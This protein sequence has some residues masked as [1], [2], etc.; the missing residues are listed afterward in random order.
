M[1]IIM[2]PPPLPLP[3]LQVFPPHVHIQ[4][5]LQSTTVHSLLLLYFTPHTHSLP[6]TYSSLILTL[7]RYYI[8]VLLLLL[9]VSPSPSPTKPPPPPPPHPPPPPRLKW[10]N[11]QILTLYTLFLFPFL[12]FFLSCSRAQVHLPTF[13]SLRC[14]ATKKKPAHVLIDIASIHSYIH[15]YFTPL[16]T[17][18]D[19]HVHTLSQLL[20]T[21]LLDHFQRSESGVLSV[22]LLSQKWSRTR[23]H[24]TALHCTAGYYSETIPLLGPFSP[25]LAVLELEDFS[26]PGY[27]KNQ[28]PSQL[29]SKAKLNRFSHS[30]FPNPKSQEESKPYQSKHPAHQP[31]PPNILSG[32][33]ATGIPLVLSLLRPPAYYQSQQRKKLPPILELPSLRMQ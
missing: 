17:S 27:T 16:P 31:S 1:I 5:Q 4:S 22:R 26:S 20:T 2:P 32:C 14:T 12:S 30:Q 11:T 10:H 13:P 28:I 18:K 6:L 19:T 8:T 15:T 24:C 7:R 25:I 23:L 33:E 29:D 21:T 3:Y 9:L